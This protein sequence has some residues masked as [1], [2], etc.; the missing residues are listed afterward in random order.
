MQEYWEAT[1]RPS[2]NFALAVVVLLIYEGWMLTMQQFGGG[3]VQN[4]VDALLTQFL[5]FIP[6]G[7]WLVWIGIGIAG[8]AFIY[9][10]QK[11]GVKY[12]PRYFG[13]MVLESMLW[14]AV[15]FV[16]LPQLMGRMFAGS[17]TVPAAAV[18]EQPGL[19]ANI[20][21]SFGAGFYEEFFFRFLLVRGLQLFMQVFKIDTESLWSVMGVIT[22][23]ALAFSGAHYLGALGDKFELYSFFYR[24][25]FG[26]LM[27]LLLV[28][29]HFGITAWTH[30]LYDVLVFV[31]R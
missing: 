2:Y 31:T 11:E 27:S 3:G 25:V 5:H 12:E 26:L 18:P 19:V 7:N 23:S 24:F 14:A 13:F 6:Y 30:A 9:L 17:A 10:D 28:L 1:K 8:I 21:L 15:L 22:F 16:L 29:R 4:G 20:G